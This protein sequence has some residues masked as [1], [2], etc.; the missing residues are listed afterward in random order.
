MK[1]RDEIISAAVMLLGAAIGAQ[2]GTLATQY[3]KG[4]KIRLYFASTMA[5]AGVSVIFKHFAGQYKAVYSSSLNSWVKSN[6]DFIQWAKTEGASI[7]SAKMQVRDW[8]LMNK[9]AVKGWLAQ[10]SDLIQQARAMEKMWNDY[11]GYLM[12]GAAVGLSILIISKMIQGIQLEKR[13]AVQA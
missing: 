9:D 5:L 6:P 12:L 13:L 7:G 3:V 8:I 1:G 2:F 11:S 10:Q 4:L